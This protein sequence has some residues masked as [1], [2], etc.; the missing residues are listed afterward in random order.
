MRV[1]L[2]FT[3]APDEAVAQRIAEAAV[4]QG[5]AACVNALAACRSTYR[6]RGAVETASEIP[7]LI[8]TTEAAYPRLEALIRELHPYELPEI[9]AVTI[10]HGLPEYLKWIDDETQTRRN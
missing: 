6:W 5:V 8:K 9:V 7:L 3:N 1:L 2:V 10:D 4:N